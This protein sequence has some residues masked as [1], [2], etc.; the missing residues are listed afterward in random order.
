MKNR[1][2]T[3]KARQH[4]T[5]YLNLVHKSNVNRN[6]T[7]IAFFICCILNIQTLIKLWGNRLSYMTGGSLQRYNSHREEPVNI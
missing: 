5:K 7:E 2:F 4:M 1:P 3:D 6:S